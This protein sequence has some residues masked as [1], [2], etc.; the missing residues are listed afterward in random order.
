MKN[1]P[2]SI[3]DPD[4]KYVSAA[5]TNIAKTFARFERPP[6]DLMHATS[7]AEAAYAI[8][9]ASTDA[10]RI[11][12]EVAPADIVK[13]IWMVGYMQGR[14]DEYNDHHNNQVTP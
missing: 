14:R 4:F 5:E 6:E 9:L 7:L 10:L 3:F 1:Q 12:Q 8:E 11:A 2:K 13:M